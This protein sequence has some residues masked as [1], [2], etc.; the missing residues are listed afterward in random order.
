M[1]QKLCLHQVSPC[2]SFYETHTAKKTFCPKA[3]IDVDQVQVLVDTFFNKSFRS[4]NRDH[5]IKDTSFLYKANKNVFIFHL[6]VLTL[7]VVHVLA[8]KCFW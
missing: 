8:L 5:S 6:D 2:S 7:V 4:S 3:S 1:E